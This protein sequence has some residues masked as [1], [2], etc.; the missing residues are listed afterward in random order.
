LRFL[1]R[2]DDE[3]RMNSSDVFDFLLRLS[4]VHKIPKHTRR[5]DKKILV[6]FGPK[7]GQTKSFFFIDS[8]HPP[9]ATF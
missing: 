7:K 1:K 3:K 8:K 4:F 6:V 2:D 9:S 5:K